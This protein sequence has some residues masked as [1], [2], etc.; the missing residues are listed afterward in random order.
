MTHMTT[1][2]LTSVGSDAGSPK[3]IRGPSPATGHEADILD[4]YG[5]YLGYD[6][7]TFP[8]QQSQRKLRFTSRAGLLDG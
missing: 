2:S 7:E 1:T 4:V 3:L 6:A 5:P 8:Y